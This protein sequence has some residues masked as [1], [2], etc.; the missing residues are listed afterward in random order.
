MSAKWIAIVALVVIV[1]AAGAGIFG[2]TSGVKAG[3]TQAADVRAAFLAERGVPGSG[4]GSGRQGFPGGQGGGA[5][6]N[7]A[8]MVT[9]QVKQVDGTTVQISTASAVETVKIDSKT[10][11]QKMA[12]ARASDLQPGERV[13]VQGARNADGT[14]T[15]QSIQVGGRFGG[16]P[17]Q[18]RGTPQSQTN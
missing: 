3:Q 18:P 5:P 10:Q 13:T 4:Q 7:P 8:N 6:F 14:F 17:P 11:I 16:A 15:A 12:A 2:Y 1:A 9:G